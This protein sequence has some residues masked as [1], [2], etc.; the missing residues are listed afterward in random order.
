MLPPATLTSQ[1]TSIG[2]IQPQTTVRVTSDGTATPTGAT[3]NSTI[4]Y[5]LKPLAFS[6]NLIIKKITTNIFLYDNIG[7]S[8]N[9]MDVTALTQAKIKAL[10]VMAEKLGCSLSQLAIAW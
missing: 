1:A 4:Y 9:A 6:R 7:N 2:G 10:T 3:G 8:T 5:Y